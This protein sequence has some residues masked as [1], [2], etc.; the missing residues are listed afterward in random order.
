MPDYISVHDHSYLG[1]KD[2]TGFLRAKQEKL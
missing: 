2:D 1:C